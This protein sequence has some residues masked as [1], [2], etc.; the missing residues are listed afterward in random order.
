MFNFILL[1]QVIKTEF[2][3]NKNIFEPIGNEENFF[4]SKVETII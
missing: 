1:D 3:S 4:I 2:K